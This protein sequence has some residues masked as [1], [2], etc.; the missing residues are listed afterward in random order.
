M[1]RERSEHSPRASE[2]HY[3]PK[4]KAARLREWAWAAAASILALIYG[5]GWAEQTGRDATAG[6]VAEADAHARAHVAERL[7]LHFEALAA[8]RTGQ[9]TKCMNST[10]SNPRAMIVWQDPHTGAWLGAFCNT[11]TLEKGGRSYEYRAEGPQ[12]G[13]GRAAGEVQDSRTATSRDL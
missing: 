4:W 11:H 13:K 3:P 5:C 7:A 12:T 6:I 10:R 8:H 1:T 2:P 9:L